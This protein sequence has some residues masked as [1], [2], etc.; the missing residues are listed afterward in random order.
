MTLSMLALEYEGY[1]DWRLPITPVEVEGYD[2]ISSEMGYMYY[3]NLENA[4][5]DYCRRLESP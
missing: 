4:A 5:T 3:V 1:D 2:I